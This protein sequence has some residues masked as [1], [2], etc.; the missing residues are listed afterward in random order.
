MCDS[1]K[2]GR[3]VQ[4]HIGKHQMLMQKISVQNYFEDNISEV[5]EL[6]EQKM[7]FVGSTVTFWRCAAQY[8]MCSV[9]ADL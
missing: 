4:N 5:A 8:G 2:F 9:G 1:M 6:K 7:T 3:Q